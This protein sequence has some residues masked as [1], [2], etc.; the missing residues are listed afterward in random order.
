MTAASGP[1]RI[2]LLCDRDGGGVAAQQSALP[3]AAQDV[4]RMVLRAFLNSGDAP[5]RRDLPDSCGVEVD[6]ALD[7]LDEVDLVHL[8]AEGR[9]VVAY[10]FAARITGQTVRVDA[11]PVL[12]AMCA[13]DA[14]GIPMLAGRDGV[15]ESA[16]PLDG[17][18]IRVECTGG[19]WRWAPAETVVL[20]ASSAE[21]GVAAEC[22]CPESPFAGL[23]TA[24]RPIFTADQT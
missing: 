8:D 9:V 12:Q 4:H 19:S 16:D 24:P 23:G 14:L 20:L 17:Q 3:P 6:E 2:E 13:I 1:L 5:H 10:P 15:I 22:L 21:C 11:G 18:P 7:L